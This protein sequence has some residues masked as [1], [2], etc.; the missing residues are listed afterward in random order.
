MLSDQRDPRCPPSRAFILLRALCVA[1]NHNKHK[2]NTKQKTPSEAPSWYSTP[3][4]TRSIWLT[5]LSTTHSS[6]PPS[7]PITEPAP[8]VIAT[9][10]YIFREVRVRVGISHGEGRTIC[11]CLTQKFKSALAGF[12]LQ[13]HKLLFQTSLLSTTKNS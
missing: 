1:Y 3:A 4:N 13:V 10:S 6:A 11:V 7:Q 9:C 8:H 12:V 5:A 2:V